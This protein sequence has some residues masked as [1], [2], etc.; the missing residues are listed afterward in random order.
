VYRAKY[1]LSVE[2]INNLFYETLKR[3]LKECYDSKK[4]KDANITI[5]KMKKHIYD[6]NKYFGGNFMQTVERIKKEKRV[7]NLESLSYY[8]G[9]AIYFLFTKSERKDKTHAM[10]EPFVNVTTF[11]TLGL[12]FEEIFSVY[13]HAL[14]LN[15]GNTNQK[16]SDIW[17]FLYD[18]RKEKFTRDLKMLF[19]A[20]YFNTNE[21]IFIENKKEGEKDV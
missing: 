13:K 8:I 11:R 9:Q 19:Y 15:W 14:K 21:N 3:K 6:L 5:N 17:S 2:D 1:Y 20:G 4:E 7:T 12:K 10:I 18:N 16:L